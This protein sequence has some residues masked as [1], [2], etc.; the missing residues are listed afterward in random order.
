MIAL[1]EGTGN[2]QAC[3]RYISLKSNSLLNR[4]MDSILH[5][6]SAWGV[7]ARHGHERSRHLFIQW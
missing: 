5:D 4:D 2:V 1:V 7:E 3:R 6:E